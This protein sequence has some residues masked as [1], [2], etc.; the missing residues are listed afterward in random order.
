MASVKT[1]FRSRIHV[2]GSLG[3]PR[4]IRKAF[5][6]DWSFQRRKDGTREVIQGTPDPVVISLVPESCNIGI[7]ILNTGKIPTLVF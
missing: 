3:T 6:R 4:N 7:D 1:G 5:E 2:K